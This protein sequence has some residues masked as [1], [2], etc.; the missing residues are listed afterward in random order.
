MSGAAARH[1][2][3][4]RGAEPY[5]VVT[6]SKQKS[7]T[8]NRIVVPLPPSNEQASVLAKSSQTP[9]PTYAAKKQLS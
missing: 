5:H 9:F 3:A 7:M 1:G 4:L 8:H 6:H 2:I